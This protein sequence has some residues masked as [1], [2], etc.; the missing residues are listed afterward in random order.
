MEGVVFTGRNEGFSKLQ[1]IHSSRKKEFIN[2]SYDIGN[3]KMSRRESVNVFVF[4]L[5]FR[6]V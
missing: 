2:D 3:K 5:H 1:Q 4:K 6:M